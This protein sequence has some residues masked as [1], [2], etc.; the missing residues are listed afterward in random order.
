[1]LWLSRNKRNTFAASLELSSDPQKYRDWK[2]I[3]CNAAHVWPAMC[4]WNREIIYAD[5]FWNISLS[6]KLPGQPC[7]VWQRGT[8]QPEVVKC[9]PVQDRAHA[10]GQREA[11]TWSPLFKQRRRVVIKT[12]FIRMKLVCVDYTFHAIYQ[13]KISL[14]SVLITTSCLICLKLIYSGKPNSD[15]TEHPGF[16][17]DIPWTAGQ[18]PKC[19]Y[20]VFSDPSPLSC[21]TFGSLQPWKR[22]N[23]PFKPCRRLISY[24]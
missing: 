13:K 4:P 19:G 18:R 22:S 10:K 8:T 17:S 15:V 6:V 2:K 16:C 11:V 12:T 1:M 23:R 21:L 5:H 3:R 9:E 24:N 20:W 14:C 7:A